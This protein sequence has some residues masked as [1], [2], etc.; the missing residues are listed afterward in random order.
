MDKLSF[1]KENFK[2]GSLVV[3]I[4]DDGIL[5]GIYEL[6]ETYEEEYRWIE[7]QRYYLGGE[8]SPFFTGFNTSN[9]LSEDSGTDVYVITKEFYY[10]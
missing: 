8:F 1:F 4:G 10:D 3:C 6:L 7:V 9:R 5:W 2:K